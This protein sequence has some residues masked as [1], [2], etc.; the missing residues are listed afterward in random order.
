MLDSEG[1]NEKQGIAIARKLLGWSN[2]A[3]AKGWIDF[4]DMVYLPLLWRLRLWQN[5]FVFIDEAQDTNPTRRALAKSALKIGGRLF[6]FGD[7]N[8]AIFGFTGANTDSLDLIRRDFNCREFPLSVSYRC[9]RAVVDLARAIVPQIES[10]EGAEAGSVAGLAAKDIP[11]TMTARDAILCRNAA[12]L[13]SLAYSLLARGTACQILGRDIAAGLVAL[14]K[15][16]SRGGKLTLADMD[17]RLG[18]FLEKETAKYQARGEEQ[19]A[20][21]LKDRIECVR[22]IAD[23]LPQPASVAKLI[24]RI[25]SMFIEDDDAGKREVLTLATIHKSKGLEWPQVAV[26]RPELMPS[27]Y[28]RQQWQQEQ[29]E[30][31]R[32]VCYT[33]AMQNLYLIEGEF[34]L[35]GG[36]TA[37]SASKAA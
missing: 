16:H 19:K 13:V 7:P 10:A 24:A 8:Q 6:A 15:Q 18:A 31:L 23:N 30:N 5:D 9:S 14:V 33:R 36:Q 20:E 21:A 26:Y 1:A 32:Y 4:D 25:E 12:P 34:S 28:A 22:V 2:D 35:P 3:A 17:S 37:Q 27:P 29:E 11:A